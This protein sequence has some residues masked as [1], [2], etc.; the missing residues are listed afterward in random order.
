MKREQIL[1]EGMTNTQVQH[2]KRLIDREAS[3]RGITSH[4]KPR[5]AGTSGQ[6]R[7]VKGGNK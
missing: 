6:H 2:T 7:A 5:K 3:R 4:G 1:L